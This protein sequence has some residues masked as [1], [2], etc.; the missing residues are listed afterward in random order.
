MGERSMVRKK[1]GIRQASGSG[2]ALKKWFDRR[3]IRAISNR[4]NKRTARVRRATLQWYAFETFKYL[5]PKITA[6]SGG[7][8][9]T[10]IR[11]HEMQAPSG[12]KALCASVII[13]WTGSPDI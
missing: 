8:M 11:S 1:R 2:M 12:P 13:I 7:A 9:V 3:T 6:A 4:Q 5:L 10:S